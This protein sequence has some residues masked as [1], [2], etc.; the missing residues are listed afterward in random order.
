MSLSNFAENALLAHIFSTYTVYV[1]YGSAAVEASMTEMVGNGYAREL[2]GAYTLTSVGLDVQFVQND[3]DIDFDEAT[4]TQG[5][6]A[7]FG[8]FDAVT[9]GNFLGSVTLAELGLDDISVILGTQITLAA[10]KCKMY[11]D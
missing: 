6:C 11:M 5:N 7:V 2:F 1:G 4:G 10:T 3:V 8:F 9:G